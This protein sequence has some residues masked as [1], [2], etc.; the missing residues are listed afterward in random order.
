MSHV[1]AALLSSSFFQNVQSNTAERMTEQ[2]HYDRLA[3][4][5]L[6]VHTEGRAVSWSGY[7]TNGLTSLLIP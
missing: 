6:A 3:E 7:W 4:T 2:P 1:G 5:R